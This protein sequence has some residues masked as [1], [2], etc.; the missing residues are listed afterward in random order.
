[1]LAQCRSR[2]AAHAFARTLLGK[3]TIEDLHGGV[4]HVLC[5]AD[6]QTSE[7]VYFSDRFVHSWRTGWLPPDRVQ[8][9]RAVQASACLP[10][11]FNVVRIGDFLLTDGGVYDNMATEWPLRL[12]RRLTEGSPP[13]PSIHPVDEVVVVNASAGRGVVRRRTARW[14]LVGE[15]SSLMAVKDVLYDQTT[16][17]RRRLLDLRYRIARSPV[18]VPIPDGA[19]CGSTIQ[20]D[21]S[22]F[23]LPR[24]FEAGGDDA[25]SRAAAVLALLGPESEEA[26]DAIAQ[27]NRRVKTSLSRIGVERSAAIVRHAYV[28]TMANCHVLLGYPL[29]ALPDDTRV[30]GVLR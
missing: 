15:I 2:V 17:T 4:S 1:M 22:P 8:L 23:D 26:W 12:D 21:R 3:K 29:L 16:A 11:A 9:A 19:L 20:I 5:A 14:P 25:A 24:A 13:R 18:P 27:A 30:R 10:G 28:L 7:N 6:I